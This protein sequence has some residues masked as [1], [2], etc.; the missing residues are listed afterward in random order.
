M[1]TI[2]KNEVKK[3]NIPDG[4][5]IEEPT[6]KQLDKEKTANLWNGKRK[7]PIDYTPI[8][9]VEK[10]LRYCK[11]SRGM[12]EG[13]TLNQY[14]RDIYEFCNILGIKTNTQIE[15]VT[16]DKI[17]T[18]FEVLYDRQYSPA[19]YNKR[20][21]T[22]KSF[23]NYLEIEDYI[24]GN[25][26]RKYNFKKIK[27]KPKRYLTLEEGYELAQY[28]RCARDKI[29]V[30]LYLST[31]MR[32]SELLSV[33]LQDI[34][35]KTNQ[36][37]VLRK[38]G[39]EQ[40][41]VVPFNIMID[42]AQYI[43]TYRVKQLKRYGLTDFDMPY[44]FISYRGMKMHPQSV[45]QI[46]KQCAKRAG[47]V[48]WNKIHNHTLRTSYATQMHRAGVSDKAIQIQLGH[49]N[50]STTLNS[51]VQMDNEQVRNET[52][53]KGFNFGFTPQPSDY[54]NKVQEVVDR[55]NKDQDY[56]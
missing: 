3:D 24:K 40:E 4:L 35:W 25:I 12:M 27:P 19:S 47:I 49:N 34:E 55:I 31:G 51:Y 54:Q 48:D 39:K 7:Y 11:I 36:I 13:T 15:R 6:K 44:L 17:D 20:L 8:N 30:K 28:T 5:I 29:I 37:V 23:Y 41:I 43:K 2:E 42:I 9:Y 1:E 53:G 52:A 14:K 26:F 16:T 50:I 10:F 32:V 46:L 21:S 45:N 38:G 56:K 18:Y 22:L 33:K